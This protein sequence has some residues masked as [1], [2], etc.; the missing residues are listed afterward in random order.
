MDVTVKELRDHLEAQLIPLD[1]KASELE[2]A[3]AEI[4]ESR[5][6]LRAAIN[7]LRGRNDNA[8]KPTRKC[9]TKDMVIE[10]AEQLVRENNSVPRADLDELVR[11]KIKDSGLSLSGFALRFNEALA[12]GRFKLSD[13]GNV[14][15]NVAFGQ[16]RLS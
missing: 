5:K 12:S 16:L 1:G 2:S 4:N 10:L 11:I 15:L 3:L 6:R 8:K 7:A 9:A 14:S 13:D